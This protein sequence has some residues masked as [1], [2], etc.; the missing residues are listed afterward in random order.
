MSSYAPIWNHGYDQRLLIYGI[1]DKGHLN[2]RQCDLNN[3]SEMT[4]PTQTATLPDGNIVVPS[5]IVGL[6][7]DYLVSNHRYTIIFI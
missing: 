4:A 3:K 1:T 7:F 5:A 2:I 6:H